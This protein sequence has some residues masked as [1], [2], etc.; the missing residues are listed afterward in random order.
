MLRGEFEQ[1]VVGLVVERRT[2]LHLDF[3]EQVPPRLP[4]RIEPPARAQGNADAGGLD[5]RFQ[6]L[7]GAGVFAGIDQR[8]REVPLRLPG[9]GMVLSQGGDHERDQRIEQ[10]RGIG[11]LPNYT[12]AAVWYRKS[13]DQN[14]PEAQANLA[15]LYARGNGVKKD[16][17]EAINW[18]RKAGAQGVA[19]AQFNL[20]VAY[21]RGEGVTTN[22]AEARK[23]Y[24]LAARQ[25]FADA[26]YNGSGQ[27]CDC[28]LYSRNGIIYARQYLDFARNFSPCSKDKDKLR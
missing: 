3:V 15:S 21:D 9:Q 20:G 17:A 16:V 12:N 14:F 4:H 23:W 1:K 7:P 26:Q 11:G 5:D 2:D 19:W 24:D 25:G 28:R 6:N 10:T 13:A 8:V 22:Y 18:W 27:W